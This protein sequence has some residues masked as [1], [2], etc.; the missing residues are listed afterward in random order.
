MVFEGNRYVVTRGTIDFVN[1]AA[2]EPYFDVEAE[3]RV[4]VADQTY[5][6]TLGF[7]GTPRRFVPTINSDPPL[8]TSDILA[9]LF[10]QDPDIAN[11]ELRTFSSTAANQSEADLLKGLTS[12]L[13]TS[14]F[15]APVGKVAEEVLGSGATVLITPNIGTEGDAL[16]PT[17]RLV[18]GKRLSSRAYLTFARGLGNSTH[19]QILVLE[20]DQNDRISWILTQNG[21]NTFAI[22]FRVRHVF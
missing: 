20:F 10:G 21:D 6:V 13:L 8:P 7:L 11:A 14:P 1:P 5:R 19:Q 4:R 16:A 15:S 18:I 22:D 17:A 2:I 3:T 9:L 12:R